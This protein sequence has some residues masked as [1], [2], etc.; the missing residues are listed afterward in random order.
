M[1]RPD[2]E[3]THRILARA[4]RGQLRGAVALGEGADAP[5][6]GCRV[7]GA[8][9]RGYGRAGDDGAE[10][11][12]LGAGALEQ[13]LGRTGL[14]AAVDMVRLAGGVDADLD[15][16]V[17]DGPDD[18]FDLLDI[19]R[20]DGAGEEGGGADEDGGELHGY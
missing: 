6:G 18:V 1:T 11:V 9:G 8:E 5:D 3:P 7:S 20:Q 12:V 14:D 10:A 4:G 13:V 2:G 15:A 16:G 17:D 19:N